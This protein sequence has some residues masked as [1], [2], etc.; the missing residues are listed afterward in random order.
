M[1]SNDFNNT[2]KNNLIN[3]NEVK[4][5]DLLKSQ[6]FNFNFIGTKFLWKE[7]MK[8]NT[9]YIERSGDISLITPY[10]QNILCS[11]LTQDNID[12]LSEEYIIQLVTLLQLTGQYLVYTQKMLEEE[13]ERL[14]DENSY[15]RSNLNENEKYSRIIDD[16]NRQNQEK[17]FLIKTYQDM[18]Q[19]RNGINDIDL[20]DNKNNKN[21]KSSKKKYYYCSL[22]SGKK[23]I[24]Q[25]YLDEHIERR[26]YNQKDLIRSSGQ[27][28][29]EKSIEKK[30]YRQ[31]FEDKLNLIVKDFEL[32]MKQQEENNDFA[33]L[34]EKIESLKQKMLEQN[35]NN[36]EL[37]NKNNINYQS[38]INYQQKITK[39]EIKDNV[40]NKEYK[41]KYEEMKKR[42]DEL[43]KKAEVDY[44]EMLMKYN[45]QEK[46]LNELQNLSNNIEK[47]KSNRI[48]NEPVKNT[49]TIMRNQ[50]KYNTNDMIRIKTYEDDNKINNVNNHIN[51]INNINTESFRQDNK[52]NQNKKTGISLN[53]ISNEQDNPNGGK[54]FDNSEKG[55]TPIGDE[56]FNKNQKENNKNIENKNINNNNNNINNN[57]DFENSEI[58]QSKNIFISNIDQEKNKKLK[59]LDN[60]NMRSQNVLNSININNNKKNEIIPSTLSKFGKA[61]E[62]RDEN[63][64]GIED[65][66]NKITIPEKYKY[67]IEQK[68][69]D[70]KEEIKEKFNSST[71]SKNVKKL[72][73]EKNNRD[74]IYKKYYEKLNEALNIEDALNSYNKYQQEKNK[75]QMI[76]PPFSKVSSIS[77]NNEK[78]DIGGTHILK[79][80]NNNI[81][82]S[83]NPYSGR[84]S[85]LSK[86]KEFA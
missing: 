41:K 84:P 79:A 39:N 48:L 43:K 36:E 16:L 22:C 24:S 64:R 86:Q 76:Q 75:N 1:N 6:E 54:I 71:N 67:N 61:F 59:A 4:N 15:L 3:S 40:T 7:L 85:K 14:I 20:D 63:Y 55:T 21:L 27:K 2:Q 46:K 5:N 42:Y 70:K 83:G 18:I 58:I 66:Y 51:D 8:L 81:I 68:I 31:V 73:E 72:M 77:N 56:S 11:R 69:E 80:S 45:E 32:K 60:N 30:N 25:K 35:L 29:E 50:N 19:T 74:S 52:N 34:N 57:N 78:N 38:S 13:N 10:V 12:M 53:D 33:L 62:E 9:K 37:I 47:D 82:S 44:K 17:D 49:N 26:H 23:F 65:D 28:E